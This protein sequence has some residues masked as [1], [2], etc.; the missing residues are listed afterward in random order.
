ARAIAG[1][2]G[3]HGPSR[4]SIPSSAGQVFELVYPFGWLGIL[5]DMPP[6]N[7]ELIYANH[8]RGFALASMRSH[9]R[10]RY[11]IQVPIDE[12]LGEWPD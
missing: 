8:E 4:Q 1:C 12:D 5:A 7:E 9:T 2:D 10:S 3:S 11:Y 6:C